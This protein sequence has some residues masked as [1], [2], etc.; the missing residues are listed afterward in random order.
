MDLKAFLANQPGWHTADEGGAQAIEK[1]WRFT[2]FAAAMAFATRVAALAERLSHHPTLTVGWGVCRV[3]WTTH[4]AGGLTANDFNA[5]R[6]TDL[7]DLGPG[8][9]PGDTGNA[10]A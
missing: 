2:D 3:R 4:D 7:L 10:A 9:L 5:A 8:A 1:A 6:Q